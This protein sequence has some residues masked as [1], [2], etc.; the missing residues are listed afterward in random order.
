MFTGLSENYNDKNLMDSLG[1]FALLL[2]MFES[3]IYLSYYKDV[4]F[5]SEIALFYIGI[6]YRQREY[7]NLKNWATTLF[8]ISVVFILITLSHNWKSAWYTKYSY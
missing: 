8:V 7:P 2:L 1:S 5:A 6:F 3:C 4:V